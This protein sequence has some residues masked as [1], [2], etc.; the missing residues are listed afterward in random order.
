MT[1]NAAARDVKSEEGGVGQGNMYVITGSK[2]SSMSQPDLIQRPGPVD[3][4]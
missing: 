1:R 4:V 2:S 3:L